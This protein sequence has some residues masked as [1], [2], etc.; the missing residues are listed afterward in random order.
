MMSGGGFISMPAPPIGHQ[1]RSPPP[2]TPL[3]G[4]RRADP[5]EAKAAEILPQQAP[6]GD[7]LFL[8]IIGER[9]GPDRAFA[10]AALLVGI[11]DVQRLF[12]AHR[13]EI[14][15]ASCRE[16]VCQYV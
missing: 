3:A 14:G 6:G 12:G 11:V 7:D 10:R 1:H 5:V 8:L 15:R 16:R 9:R 4:P 2:E 13:L